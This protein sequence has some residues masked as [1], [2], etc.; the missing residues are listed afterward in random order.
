MKDDEH[1]AVEV[2][3]FVQ[4]VH[5]IAD[6][7]AERMG[8]LSAAEQKRCSIR[9]LS[10]WLWVPSSSEQLAARGRLRRAWGT[11]SPPSSGRESKSD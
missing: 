6:L 9:R 7:L 2:T 1:L 8:G 4:H 3:Q 11:K 10:A 5:D